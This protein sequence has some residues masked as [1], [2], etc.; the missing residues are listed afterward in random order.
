VAGAAHR[1]TI[2]LLW[3]VACASLVA[4]IVLTAHRGGSIYRDTADA[5]VVALGYATVGL[6]LVRRVPENAIS[7]LF[8]AVGVIA[9]VGLACDAYGARTL[10]LP[11]SAALAV[12]AGL[13]GPFPI[14]VLPALLL[15]YPSGHLPSPRWKPVAIAWVCATGMYLSAAVFWPGRLGL[16]SD[17]SRRNPI[18]IGGTLG[19]A[20]SV[21]GFAAL[22]ISVLLAIAAAASLVVR[23][24]RA[25]GIERQQLKGFAVAAVATC[26]S[27]PLSGYLSSV[28]SPLATDVGRLLIPAAATGLI[29]AT[30]L[31]VVRYRLY[32]IDVIVRRTLTYAA[33]I[34]LLAATY[35]ACVFALGRALD[36][37]TG[38]SGTLAVTISTLAVAALF[39]PLRARI[40]RT[41]DHRFNRSRYDAEQVLRGFGGR[42]RDQIDLSALEADVLDVVRTTVQPQHASLW[43]QRAS[44]GTPR[45]R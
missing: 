32:D 21:A 9:G 36:T 1:W 13:L 31:A 37:I 30:G 25:R 33:L 34:V 28:D 12:A 45:L 8:L 27:V 26:A 41:V 20:I 43:L 11:G 35:L 22:L 15:I 19:G 40:Q 16:E 14:F 38:Q 39:Q 5:G 17:P 3:A 44:E 24:R 42:L 6:A 23:F 2:W 4:A 10:G 29:V 18:G 7:W